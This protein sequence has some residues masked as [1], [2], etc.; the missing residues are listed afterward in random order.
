M[1]KP[2]SMVLDSVQANTIRLYQSITTHRYANP[3]TIGTNV[4]SVLQT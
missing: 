2:A 1:Q 3:P 4:M